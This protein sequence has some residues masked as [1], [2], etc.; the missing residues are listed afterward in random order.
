MYLITGG[1]G[2][3]GSHLVQEL[4]RYQQEVRV[5][6][7]FFT[8]RKENLEGFSHRVEII[9][10]DIRDLPTVR[11]AMRGVRY[12]LHQAAIRSVPRSVEDPSSTNE[13][14]AQGTLNVLMAARDARVQRVVYAS[15]SSVYGES[16]LKTQEEG[17]RPFPISPYAVS[18][19]SGE[20]YCRLFSR[21]YGLETVA[22]R[23]FSVFG[24][25]QDG[26]SEYAAVIPRFILQALR[27]EPVEVHGDGLQS[28]DFTYVSDVVQAN[29]L[30]AKAPNVAGEVFNVGV[31]ESHTV[32]DIVFFLSKFLGR[33]IQWHKTASRKGDVR[34][35]QAD[36]SKAKRLLGY[37]VEVEFP[38]GLAL[39][40]KHLM[41]E[42]SAA[43]VLAEGAR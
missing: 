28:R 39:I 11:K 17:Q 31:G 29:L 9:E 4:M 37:E 27:G 42:H 24:P 16:Q 14:N 7:N 33:E 36:V 30:A 35:T 25:R 19:L 41:A 18:K 6:D 15:S 21:L 23:Y 5:L 3:I 10:G 32:M 20:L 40:V 13:V 12:V 26:E 43:R 38:V 22:L 34:R 8:G 2:F 1:A